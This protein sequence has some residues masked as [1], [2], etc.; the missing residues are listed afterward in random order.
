MRHPTTTIAIVAHGGVNRAILADALGTLDANIFRIG[1]DYAAINVIDWYSGEPSVLRVSTMS[2][3]ADSV[4]CQ[5]L[6]CLVR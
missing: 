6:V 4:Q 1:Q 3:G 5:A 2:L